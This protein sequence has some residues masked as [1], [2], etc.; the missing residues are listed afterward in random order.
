MVTQARFPSTG[1]KQPSQGVGNT[2]FPSPTEGHWAT[3]HG[4]HIFIRNATAVPRS[5]RPETRGSRPGARSRGNSTQNSRGDRAS[6]GNTPPSPS[7]PPVNSG[8]AG[9]QEDPVQ[10]ELGNRLYSQ[11]TSHVDSIHAVRNSNENLS[12]YVESLSSSDPYKRFRP[13][14][15]LAATTSNYY[16]MGM[17]TGDA[18]DYYTAVFRFTQNTDRPLGDFVL[19]GRRE[20][21]PEFGPGR[22]VS[23]L[24]SD[25]PGYRPGVT[26]KKNLDVNMKLGAFHA[27][28]NWDTFQRAV[29]SFYDEM[30]T[31]GEDSEAGAHYTNEFEKAFGTPPRKEKVESLTP[32]SVREHMD[33]T[34]Y[35]YAPPSNAVTESA[36]VDNRPPPYRD[37]FDLDTPGAKLVQNSELDI[38]TLRGLLP[39]FQSPPEKPAN[40]LEYGSREYTDY[41]DSLARWLTVSGTIEG[42]A[43]K[44]HA[45]YNGRSFNIVAQGTSPVLREA[46]DSNK[47]DFRIKF[48]EVHSRLSGLLSPDVSLGKF[49]FQSDKSDRAHVSRGVGGASYVSIST[50]DDVHTIIHELGHVVE[51]QNP[52]IRKAARDFLE[53]RTRPQRA[54]PMINLT[55]NLGYERHEMADPDGFEKPY[56]GKRYATGSTEIVSMG[57]ERM[58]DPMRRLELLANDPAYFALMHDIVS[59]HYSR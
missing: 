6:G 29:F 30:D 59:G 12:D 34:G 53:S 33:S 28:P 48:T 37:Y 54:F 25:F 49:W 32:E 18:V 39:R 57:L 8:R 56:M 35:R 45:N 23:M 36:Y 4:H 24:P 7:N 2:D 58:A 1:D 41:M 11:I 15:M 19:M 55:S 51:Q 5:G 52:R 16:G 3:V 50:K 38:N 40:P 47:D 13:S 21:D 22:K 10:S 20:F 42:L 43:R 14:E 26:D 27:A 46:Y 17:I 9:R 44:Y 31:V